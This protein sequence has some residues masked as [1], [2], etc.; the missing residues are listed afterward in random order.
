VT[1]AP[2]GAALA[3]RRYGSFLEALQVHFLAELERARSPEIGGVCARATV[4][5]ARGDGGPIVRVGDVQD[6]AKPPDPVVE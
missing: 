2:D 4:D 1:D 6:V 5:V 3:N